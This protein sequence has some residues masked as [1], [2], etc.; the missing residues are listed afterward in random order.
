MNSSHQSRMFDL[1]DKNWSEWKYSISI[2]LDA[3]EALG[4]ANGTER[5][6]A[7][8]VRLQ[9]VWDAK[10]RKAK[11]LIN[12]WIG[13]FRPYVLQTTT[14]AE[15]WATLLALC[16]RRDPQH[17]YALQQQLF[18]YKYRLG[19]SMKDHIVQVQKLVADLR[20]VGEVVTEV[21]VITK[22]LA[23]LPQSFEAMVMSWEA[24][25]QVE[26][27]LINLIP[28]LTRKDMFDEQYRKQNDAI[29]KEETAALAAGVQFQRRTPGQSNRFGNS[30]Q[31]SGQI[32]P[33]P[34]G[35]KCNHCKE[36]GHKGRDCTNRPNRP[37][38]PPQQ[39]KREQ[40]RQQ[41]NVN[42]AN[43]ENE[44]N[45]HLNVHAFT[46]GV[47]Q[48][49][50]TAGEE[51]NSIWYGDSGAGKHITFHREWFETFKELAPGSINIVLGDLKKYPAVGIGT[52]C[53]RNSR[54][55]KFMLTN[56]LYVPQI[57]RNLFSIGEVS[58]CHIKQSSSIIL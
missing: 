22:L 34:F 31:N 9:E 46:V 5:R 36:K 30:Q 27:T 51:D 50:L 13:Q 33:K 19:M 32:A 24:R 23:S 21:A 58:V 26:K 16:E 15:T 2:E 1:T 7:V 4:V 10:N 28:L 49:V 25:P 6:P 43:V 44:N 55:Q 57:G 35:G 47:E 8:G 52:V 48:Q 53:V 41:Q 17:V 20:A 3:E 12:H 56:T 18:A 37:Q 40:P 42:A 29:K 39:Q 14:A 11:R 45:D 54:G 38:Q